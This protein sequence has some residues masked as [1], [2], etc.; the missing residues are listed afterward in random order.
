MS[1]ERLKR[2]GRQLLYASLL[3][4]TAYGAVTVLLKHAD[5]D[6]GAWVDSVLPK[7]LSNWD[8]RVLAKEAHS[9]FQ[10]VTPP[11]KLTTYFTACRSQLGSLVRCGSC[12]GT[13]TARYDPGKGITVW[14]F[15]IS[16]AGFVNGS[17]NIRVDVVR[18][19]G[20][21]WI[22]GFQVND[23]SYLKERNVASTNMVPHSDPTKFFADTLQLQSNPS[24]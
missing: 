7:I 11:Q 6:A 12:K 4:L 18:E 10:R 2:F 17:A 3:I 9:E 8:D 16:H 19:F 5:K 15:Y 1:S 20:R 13:L 24:H 14:G 22:L 21:W 23:I